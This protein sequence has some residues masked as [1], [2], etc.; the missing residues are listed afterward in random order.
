M[1]ALILSA[2]DAF[3]PLVYNKSE[4][5]EIKIS[6]Q[7]GEIKNEMRSQCLSVGTT[8]CSQ[9][10][11]ENQINLEGCALSYSITAEEIPVY[12]VATEMMTDTTVLFVSGCVAFD[13]GRFF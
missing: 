10:K 4:K 11:A 7:K 1:C 5:S 2:A 13:A 12:N 8:L 9:Q 3:L 6:I